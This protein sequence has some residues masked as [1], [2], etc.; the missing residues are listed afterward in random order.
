MTIKSEPVELGRIRYRV[1]VTAVQDETPEDALWR[2]F[3]AMLDS[4]PA[5]QQFRSLRA[6]YEHERGGRETSRR[7]F[8][9]MI[10]EPRR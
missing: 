5:E 4:L 9:T 8:L 7:V 2:A 3:D 10:S 6:S 1:S